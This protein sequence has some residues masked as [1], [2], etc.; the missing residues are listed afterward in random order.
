MTPVTSVLRAPSAGPMP[1]IAPALSVECIDDRWRFTGLRHEWNELLRHSTADCPFLTW[2]WLNAWWMHFGAGSALRIVTVR[3]GD[4]LIAIAPL[5]ESASPIKWMS[6]LEF[7]GT[8]EAGSDYLDMIVAS[9]R[10]PEAL[11]ALAQFARARRTALRLTHLLPTSMAETVAKQLSLEG[12][13]SAG[14]ADGVCPFI[15]LAGHTWDSYLA[16][17]GSSHRANVRRRLR[18]LEQR[19]D[20]RFERVTDDAER[21]EALDALARFHDRRYVGRGGSTAFSTPA[22]LAFHNEITRRGIELG[23]MRLYTLRLNGAVAAVMYG[24]AYNRRFYFYQ[25][26]FDEHYSQHSAGLVLMALTI[27][28]AIDEG[29]QEFDFLWGEEG[30]KAL[31]SHDVRRLRQIQLYPAGISGRMHQRAVEAQ[32]RLRRLARRVIP[33]GDS[34]GT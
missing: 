33:R 16:T 19:F 8:G 13:T 24:F 20:V 6:R 30:Y 1:A 26:G 34:S 18:G 25:H 27:R 32:R 2:E 17:I 22:L 4:E 14:A 12:W 29:L 15:R 28:S 23:W 21:R 9:G 31:W 5:R 10:E 3:D 11:T 7:L